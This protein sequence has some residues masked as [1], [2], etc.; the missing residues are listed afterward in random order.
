MEEATGVGI[1]TTL[2]IIS[3]DAKSLKNGT[4]TLVE[5]TIILKFEG[6]DKPSYLVMTSHD[7]S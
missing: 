2:H 6:H 7:K 5:C 4:G 3:L 1:V